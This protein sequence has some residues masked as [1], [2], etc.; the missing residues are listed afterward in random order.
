MVSSASPDQKNQWIHGLA[1]GPGGDSNADI[2]EI[3]NLTGGLQNTLGI[4]TQLKTYE[5]VSPVKP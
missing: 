4:C 2:L 5:L 1:P 3:G